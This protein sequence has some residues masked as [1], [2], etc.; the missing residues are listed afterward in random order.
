MW[1]FEHRNSNVTFVFESWNSNWSCGSVCAFLSTPILSLFLHSLFC[2]Y[3]SFL[4]SSSPPFLFFLSF[5]PFLLCFVLYF[6][7]N[8]FLCLFPSFSL[9]SVFPSSFLP[10]FFFFF[11]KFRFHLF[12]IPPLASPFF[13]SFLLSL[14]PLSFSLTRQFAHFR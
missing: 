9:S 10:L 7:L 5:L 4:L 3:V 1:V 14:L 12:F 2:R 6:V 11:L 8:S 13:I